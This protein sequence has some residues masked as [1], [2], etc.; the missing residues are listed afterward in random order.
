[1]AIT[2][3]VFAVLMEPGL[4]NIW[5]DSF[6]EEDTK[7]TRTFNVR[8]MPKAKIEDTKLGGFGPLQDM[9]DGSEVKFD[10]PIAPV[11]KSYEASTKGLGYKI[12]D[13]IHRH[14]LYGEVEKF[15]R[16]LLASARH[17]SETA[18]WA[19]LNNGFTGGGTGF[20]SLQL[21]SAVHPNQDGSG[22]TQANRPAT[23]EALSLTALHNAMI[24]IRKWKNDRGLPRQHKPN[25]VHVPTDLI[26]T[27][28]E[29]LNSTL[30]PGTAN[31]DANVISRFNLDWMEVEYLTSTTAWFLTCDKHDLNYFWDFAPETSSKVDF[32]TETILRKVRQSRVAGF[33]EW[34][35]VWGTDGTP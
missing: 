35:G 12:T 16:D 21:F 2:P 29:L 7:F 20:D 32:M 34:R 23:D 14:D 19:V 31:N 26:I 15:E 3:Q 25:T 18:A 1:M 27:I 11:S 17:D 22:N 5:H 8:D 10:D 24:G 13:K 4:S 30:K 6:T 28:D 33:G 9:N